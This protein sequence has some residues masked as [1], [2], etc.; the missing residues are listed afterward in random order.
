MILFSQ[1]A[2]NINRINTQKV[3]KQGLAHDRILATVI[4]MEGSMKYF[5]V[6]NGFLITGKV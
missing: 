1:G 5:V 4:I 6:K 3:L 2:K